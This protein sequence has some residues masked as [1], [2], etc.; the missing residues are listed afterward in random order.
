MTP[1][2]EE[3]RKKKLVSAA[4]NLISGQ[5]GITVASIRILGCLHYLGIEW[6]NSYSVFKEYKSSLPLEI[7]IGTERLNWHFDELLKLDP[8]LGDLEA[9]YR[10]KLMSEACVIVTK[11]R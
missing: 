1:E 9:N 10:H 5:Q 6:V 8:I 4:R 11:Y 2:Q 7:P 3:A